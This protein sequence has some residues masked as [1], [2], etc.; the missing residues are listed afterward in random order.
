[1]LDSWYTDLETVVTLG[2][3]GYYLRK[4]RPPG[5]GNGVLRGLVLCRND[6]TAQRQ[7]PLGGLP[8]ALRLSEG[9]SVTWASVPLHG[10]C[11]C[12]SYRRFHCAQEIGWNLYFT[13]LRQEPE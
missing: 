8:L 4:H 7:P 9:S 12:C 11:P 3:C 1:M 10:Y 5:I 6:Y 2:K 13:A